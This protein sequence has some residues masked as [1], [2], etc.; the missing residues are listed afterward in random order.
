MEM[1]ADDKIIQTAPN[2]TGK[3]TFCQRILFSN[4]KKY[5]FLKLNKVMFE[6]IV[7]T[8]SIK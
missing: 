6:N 3:R 8:G 4:G 2:G 7:L 5:R 1:L